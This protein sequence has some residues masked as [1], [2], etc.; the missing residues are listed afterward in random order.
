MFQSLRLARGLAHRHFV[1]RAL[2]AGAITQS[3]AL[4]ILP[5]ANGP[6][7][8]RAWVAAAMTSSLQQLEDGIRN[9]GNEPPQGDAFQAQSLW[10]R[11]TPAQQDR[12]DG[13]MALAEEQLGHGCPRWQ[14]LESIC[15]EFLGSFGAWV[16]EKHQWDEEPRPAPEKRSD[17]VR[18][19][20]MVV[21]EHLRTLEQA[22]RVA[23][24]PV[25]REYE[26]ARELDARLRELLAARRGYDLTF[27]VLAE[28]IASLCFWDVLGYR[29]MEEY[30]RE[31]LGIAP[32]SVRE[33]VWLERRMSALP[34]LREALRSGELTYSKALLVAKD[35]TAEVVRRRIRAAASTTWQQTEH[36]SRLR[37]QRRNR[38][39]G[40]RRE[41]GPKA[42]ARTI[43]VAI[44]T[45]QECVRHEF[46]VEIDSG[47]ALAMIAD[48]F[49]EVWEAHK[50]ADPRRKPSDERWEAR[51][52]ARGL[53]AAPGCTRPAE[54]L[55]HVIFRSRGGTDDVWNQIPLCRRHHLGGVHDGYLEV[56]GRAGERLTWKPAIGEVWITEGDDDVK[57]W[58]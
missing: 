22:Y 47:E 49:V 42:A 8:E 1:R 56:T 44:E 27:G 5:V 18:E 23:E 37:E 53:C 3:K 10:L 20:A 11:M 30:C 19:R 21:A 52:R 9:Q 14:C 51:M 35:A 55:H 34:E 4:A 40:V 29:G 57:L 12:L 16:P 33:R 41:W 28:R 32:R 15:Q 39:A 43:R 6:H 58:A 31:R 45:V 2:V 50:R 24:E 46:G 7:Q 13:A 25:P 48:H 54:Q 38:A 36:K 17:E 26:S